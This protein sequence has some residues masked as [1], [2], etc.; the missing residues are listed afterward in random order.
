MTGCLSVATWINFESPFL[1]IDV[2]RLT[3]FDI[4]K[5]VRFV[6]ELIGMVDVLGI[7]LVA[8]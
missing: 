6:V 1:S 4:H 7:D 3:I 8:E 2:E 5:A